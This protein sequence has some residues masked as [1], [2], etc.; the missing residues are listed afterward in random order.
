MQAAYIF[1]VPGVGFCINN[2]HDDTMILA[3]E[4]VSSPELSPYPTIST[5]RNNRTSAG[6]YRKGPNDL[7]YNPTG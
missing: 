7:I 6:E 5:A 1:L 2:R 4:R 3:N